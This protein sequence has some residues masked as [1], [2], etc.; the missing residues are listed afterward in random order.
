MTASKYFSAALRRKHPSPHARLPLSPASTEKTLKLHDLVLFGIGG[1]LGSGLF[2]LTGR[3][4]R[5]LAGPAVTMSFAVAAMACLFS[6]LSYAEMSSRLPNSGGAY[7]FSYAGLGELPAFLVGMCLTLEYGVSAAAIARSWAS[8]LADAVPF[9]P[10]WATGVDSQFSFLAFL[11]VAALSVVLA[12]G[13]REAKWVINISTILYALIVF[14]II[15]FGSFNVDPSNW[16]PFLPFGFKGVIAASSAIFFSYVGFDEIATMSEEAIDAARTVPLAIILSMLAVTGMYIA[17][18][19]ILTGLV[20]YSQLNIDAPFSVAFRSVGLP[21]VARIVAIG[22]ALGMTNTAAVSLAAQPRIFLSMGR[23]G[24]LPRTFARSTRTSTLLCG[25]IVSLL[26]AVVETQELADVVSGGTLLAFLATNVTLLLTRT[27]IHSQTSKV[28]TVIYSFVVASA[29]CGLFNKLAASKA[30]PSWIFM[31][32]AIPACLVPALMLLF[33]EFEG[34]EDVER[35]P[36]AF[37]CPLVPLVPLFGTFTTCF[38]L[39]QLSQKALT[40]LCS[41]LIVSSAAYFMY[42]AHNALLANE[43]LILHE[44]PG[45]GSYNSFDDLAMEA[46][47]IASETPSDEILASPQ[48]TVEDP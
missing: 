35:S 16:N 17:S 28:P 11:L 13:M 37:L 14:I 4:A 15:G 19:L 21:L 25:A 18:S 1:A 47:S 24:L 44:S 48:E 46:N 45:D 20:N 26:A 7:S 6:A 31:V 10:S 5:D 42:G 34:G 27:R 30:L 12:M 2:L 43:Y 23:D 22:T 9:L 38:L 3:A 36:P 39:F 33:S 41:W 32:V 40:A 8:Y 29:L